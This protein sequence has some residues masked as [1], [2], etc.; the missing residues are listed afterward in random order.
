MIK[1][2]NVEKLIEEMQKVNENH[3]I[4]TISEILRLFSIKATEELT[5]QIRRSS[6]G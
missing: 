1:A 6:N 2:E 5:A 4:L 3:E